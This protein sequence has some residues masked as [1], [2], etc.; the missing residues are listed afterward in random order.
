[1]DGLAGAHVVTEEALL[2]RG[3]VLDAFNLEG[4]RAA[5]AGRRNAV[6]DGAAER[7]LAEA[8][9]D[10]EFELVGDFEDARSVLDVE[11]EVPG[12]FDGLVPASAREGAEEFEVLWLSGRADGAVGEHASAHVRQVEA[13]MVPHEPP[14]LKEKPA[15]ICTGVLHAAQ[16]TCFLFGKRALVL[17]GF[18]VAMV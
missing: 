7:E 3:E 5:S 1:L 18:L 17:V 8:G 14:R 6:G 4:V 13:Q 9:L 2:V 12:T 16:S 15:P 10:I 11:G